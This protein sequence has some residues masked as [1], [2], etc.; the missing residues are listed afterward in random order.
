VS[1]A[2][3]RHLAEEVEV[4]LVL[5]GVELDVL[6]AQRAAADGVGLL[7]GVLLVADAEREL[8]DQVHL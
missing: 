6:D 5:A 4:E 1:V 3:A 8:V 2:A 7:V